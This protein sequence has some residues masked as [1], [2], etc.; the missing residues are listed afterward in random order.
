MKA[1]KDKYPIE[2]MA[3][4]LKVSKSGYYSYAKRPLSKRAQEDQRLIEKIKRVYEEGRKVYGS[5]RIHRELKKTGESCSRKRVAKL[6]QQHGIKAKTNKQWKRRKKPILWSAPNLLNQQ[7]NASKPDEIWVADITYVKTLD[8]WLYVASILDLFSKKI[9]GLSMDNRMEVSLV[10]SALKQAMISRNPESPV[11]HHSDR[12]SQ[13]TSEEFREAAQE[14][15]IIL[16]MNSGSCY[17]NA[18]KES[19]F[20]TLKTE[21]VYL[22]G[23]KSREETKNNLFE[24]IEVFYN[25]KRSHSSLGYVSPRS[26]EENYYKN[27]SLSS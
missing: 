5:P 3:K 19:F 6:M 4:L 27:R 25:G 26:F 8:G 14:C 23:L 9:I 2:K 1:H 18:V 12:G 17:D 7:F 21:Y 10:K 24:F 13:Y 16:S 15:N 22:N 11:I 20:H